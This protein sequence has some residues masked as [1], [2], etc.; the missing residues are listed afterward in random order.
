MWR[1]SDTELVVDAI[2]FIQNDFLDVVLPDV[3]AVV[4]DGCH[5]SLWVDC[6]CGSIVIVTVEMVGRV[7]D[8]WDECIKRRTKKMTIDKKGDDRQKR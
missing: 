7:G 8:K 3:R 5:G 2:R 6:N 1:Q 4:V